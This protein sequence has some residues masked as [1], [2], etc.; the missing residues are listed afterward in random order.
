MQME[1]KTAS[2]SN[3]VVSA[4]FGFLN[5]II[6]S[7]FMSP[8]TK[9]SSLAICKIFAKIHITYSKILSRRPADGLLTR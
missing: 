5:G 2:A 4:D 7:E 3:R 9:Y 6:L 1:N 8:G